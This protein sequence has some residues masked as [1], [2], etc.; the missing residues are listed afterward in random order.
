MRTAAGRQAVAAAAAEESAARQQL[1]D[2]VAQ[3]E[4]KRESEHARLR[5]GVEKAEQRV[6]A[7]FDEHVRAKR[8][9]AEAAQ[10]YSSSVSPIETRLRDLRK[11]LR[12]SITPEAREQ[13]EVVR[14]E[15]DELGGRVYAFGAGTGTQGTDPV[16]KAELA[17]SRARADLDLVYEAPDGD[18]SA[19]LEKIH[20]AVRL[21]VY[22]A[23][24]TLD[25]D[26]R[27]RKPAA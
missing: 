26:V 23:L 27:P 6:R 20:A 3:L 17:V 16:R 19:L 2:E 4:K 11:Q 15:V 13:I 24:P 22:A 9:C 12:S 10:A 14:N 18:V 5:P 25:A 1:V 21:G 7:T 8:E